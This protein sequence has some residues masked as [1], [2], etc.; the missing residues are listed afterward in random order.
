MGDNEWMVTRSRYGW[1]PRWRVYRLVSSDFMG[2]R[3]EFCVRDGKP[4]SFWFRDTAVDFA[5]ML[6]AYE[7]S[8]R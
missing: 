3:W 5:E 7:G 8:K 2:S 6:N 1:L 4:I